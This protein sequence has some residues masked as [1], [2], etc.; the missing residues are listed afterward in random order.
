MTAAA[1]PDPR[2]VRALL[3]EQRLLVASLLG[4]KEQLRG[5]LVTRFATCGKTGCACRKGRAHGPYYVLST[6]S[7]GRG[8][9][10]YLA[11]ERAVEAR[12]LTASYRRF[13]TGMRRL[14]TL[15]RRLVE[16]LQRYQ[17]VVARRGARRVAL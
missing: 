4:Q 8:G 5:S 11:R 15:N 3:S 10:T 12:R 1:R 16:A 9:F 13:R 14:R 7:A 6:R 2:R 17:R